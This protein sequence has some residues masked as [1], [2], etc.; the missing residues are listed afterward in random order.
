M[1]MIPTKA[2]WDEQINVMNKDY[3]YSYF[4]QNIKNQV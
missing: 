4:K 3:R 2:A 1:D